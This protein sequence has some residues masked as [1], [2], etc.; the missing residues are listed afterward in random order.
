M[1]VFW[2]DPVVGPGFQILE[3]PVLCL[4]FENRTRLY[5][6]P[7]SAFWDGFKHLDPQTAV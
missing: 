3:I 4:R 1:K 2:S 6:G 7:E 5:L